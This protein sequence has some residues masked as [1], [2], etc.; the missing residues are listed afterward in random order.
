MWGI[1][2]NTL[3]WD[4]HIKAQKT[5]NTLKKGMLYLKRTVM[6]G[7]GIKASTIITNP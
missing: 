7:G 5:L 3:L 4:S 1:G 2:R 6:A